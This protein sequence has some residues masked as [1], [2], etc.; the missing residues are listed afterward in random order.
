MRANLIDH[1]GGTLQPLLK[2]YR[3]RILDGNHLGKT[4]HRLKVLRNTK[5]DFCSFLV[6]KMSL[7]ANPHLG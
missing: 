5:F 7:L 2:G 4:N 3:T 6:V 1:C